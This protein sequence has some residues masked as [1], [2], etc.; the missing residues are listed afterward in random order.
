MASIDEKNNRQ[1]ITTTSFQTASPFM[2][3]NKW[4]VNLMNSCSND[5]KYGF[6]I[7]S[8]KFL[9]WPIL[10]RYGHWSLRLTLEGIKRRVTKIKG[11]KDYSYRERFEK[12]EINNSG[13]RMRRNLI[14]IFKIIN[15]FLIMADI[16]LK[17]FLFKLEI[18]CQSRFQ[19]RCFFGTI[20]LIRSKTAKV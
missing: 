6:W 9:S 10:S 7:K 18:C 3:V 8:V 4:N 20:C 5:K 13:R 16:F 12:L 11:V 15:E 1:K 17:I 19:K 14:E 2:R